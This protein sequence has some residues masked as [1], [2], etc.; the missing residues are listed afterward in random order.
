[1]HIEY[2]MNPRRFFQVTSLAIMTMTLAI[3]LADAAPACRV[4]ETRTISVQPEF[5][6]GWPTLALRRSGDLWLVWSGG[7]EAHVCPFGK[8]EAMVSHDFGATWTWPRTLLDS[9]TDDRDAGRGR[10]RA[11]DFA[12][13]DIHLASLR[14]SAALRGQAMATRA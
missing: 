6:H 2:R 14:I 5:Y 12:G 7:R 8:V 10:D 4:I 9:A 1:M 3:S 13:D 11:R